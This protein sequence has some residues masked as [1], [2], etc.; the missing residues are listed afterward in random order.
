MTYRSLPVDFLFSLLV[1]YVLLEITMLLS[2]N[3]IINSNIIIIRIITITYK[4]NNNCTNNIST[5]NYT[6]N[7]YNNSY[8]KVSEF[9]NSISL[10]RLSSVG[11]MDFLEGKVVQRWNRICPQKLYWLHILFSFTWKRPFWRKRRKKVIWFE[12]CCSLRLAWQGD[13][14]RKPSP[15]RTV[16]LRSQHSCCRFSS[17]RK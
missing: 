5:T 7:N 4:R 16:L 9:D 3:D 17:W 11:H 12:S 1:Y 15:Q 6:S 8:I 13:T 2:N 10:I 14:W